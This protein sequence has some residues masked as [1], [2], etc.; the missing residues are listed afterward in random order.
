MI[1]DIKELIANLSRDKWML[2]EALEENGGEL[3]DEML[4][5]YDRLEE[6]KALLAGDGIDELGRWLKSI[7]DEL[8]MRKAEADAAARKVKNLKRYEDYAKFVI[9]QAMDALGEEKAK[10]TF[11]GFSRTTSTTNKVN[12][13]KVDYEF[14]D[15]ATSAARDAGLPDFIDVAIVTN[16]TRI[17]EYIENHAGE[18]MPFDP[19]TYIVENSTPSLRFTKPRANQKKEGE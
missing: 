12:S 14:L 13:E 18:D 11:Y 2:E 8:A 5:Q 6:M 15:A 9:G 7:Q 19:F 1:K 16:V 10:G 4:T 3:T 17:K